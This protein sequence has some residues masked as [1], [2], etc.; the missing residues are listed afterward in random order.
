[1]QDGGASSAEHGGAAES[2]G[3]DEAGLG[4]AAERRGPGAAWPGWRRAARRS[5]AGERGEG[6]GQVAECG[7]SAPGQAG[8]PP[9]TL[10]PGAVGAVAAAV[11]S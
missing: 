8:F 7:G 11:I 2:A 9:G 1:M 3:E 10:P 6:G 5:A 4:G